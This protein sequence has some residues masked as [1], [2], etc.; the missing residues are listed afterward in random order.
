MRLW[1]VVAND[2]KVRTQMPRRGVGVVAR[3]DADST[4]PEPQAGA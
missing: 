1:R 4:Q 2:V 3:A